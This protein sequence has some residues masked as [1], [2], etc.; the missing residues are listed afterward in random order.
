MKELD[1]HLDRIKDLY[2][3]PIKESKMLVSTNPTV[4][5]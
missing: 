4:A 3:S 1:E 5:K 2:T